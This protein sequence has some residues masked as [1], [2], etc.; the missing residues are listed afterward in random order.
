LVA[1][2][3]HRTFERAKELAYGL[4]SCTGN[5][6]ISSMLIAC[7]KQFLDWT[8]VYQLFMNERMDMGKFFETSS[9]VC[10]EHLDEKQMIIAHMDD[11]I[12]RKVGRKVFGCSWRR[13][14]LGPAFHTNFVWGQRF[15][16]ISLSMHDK[17]FHSESRAIAVDFHHC[18]SV[19]KIGKDAT[20]EQIVAF[21]EAKKIQ[22]LSMQGLERIK[23]FRT[24]LDEQGAYNRELYLSV[25]GSYTNETILKNL[26]AR[27]TLIGRI[28][29]DVSLNYIPETE[30]TKGRNRVYGEP[31]PTPEQIRQSEDIQW[32]EVECFAAGKT[33]TFNVK[34]VKSLKWR[35]AGK[36]HTLQMVVIRPLGYRLK[37]GGR[38]LYR[39][40]AYLIC[41]DN[42]L[43]IEKLLQAYIWRWEIEV[44]FREQKSING[45]GDAQVRNEISAVKTPAFVVA[46]H[47]FLH[48]AEYILKKENLQI[49]LPKAKWDKKATGKR[50]STNCLLNLFRGYYWFE[51]KGKSFSDFLI[52]QHHLTKQEK[53]MNYGFEASFYGRN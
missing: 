28:R 16:Q 52:K 7:G 44:N 47:S 40:P 13:D 29:K 34:I 31:C 20:Q 8:A 1:F 3:Q 25:D 53:A 14:P 9:K 42:E 30:K 23:L 48:L 26:P 27:V 22:N 19:Q 17:S 18:P 12:I 51:Q 36:A 41:T 35:V 38:L 39:K 4:L 5:R 15:I 46:V 37:K 6:T 10:I 43:A 11:T 32:Q 49:A 33:H 50:A 24:R 45:C 2:K 21:K